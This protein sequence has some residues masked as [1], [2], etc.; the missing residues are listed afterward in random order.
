M[1]QIGG[2]DFTIS[3]VSANNF[4]L[5]GLDASG[6]ATPATALT[7][8]RI[9]KVG[10]VEPAFLFITGITQA[11]SAVLTVSTEH[12]YLVGQALTLNVPSSFGMTEINGLT[13]TITAVG[14]YTITLDINSSGFSSFAFPLSTA[15]PTGRL[16]ATAGPAGQ[17]NS[18]DVSFAPFHTGVDLPY[19]VLGAGATGPA[20]SANDEIVFQAF[21]SSN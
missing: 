13:G 15:S 1:L 9:S 16:F 19:M 4:T 3:N 20:G 14:A 10:S 5:L 12:N 8:R 21:K 18:Y 17:V 2:M 7:A 11:N 6:F